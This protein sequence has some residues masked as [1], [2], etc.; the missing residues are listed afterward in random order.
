MLTLPHFKI[1][2]SVSDVVILLCII[3]SAKVSKG[4]VWVAYTHT[5]VQPPVLYK[6]EQACVQKMI[7]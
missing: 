6:M 2:C 4:F 1:I 7:L 5:Q 3:F